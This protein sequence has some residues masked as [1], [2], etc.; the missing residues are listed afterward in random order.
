MDPIDLELFNKGLNCSKLASLFSSPLMILSRF[1]KAADLIIR[2][3]VRPN[4]SVSKTEGCLTRR[5]NKYLVICMVALT[6]QGCG[7]LLFL[8]SRYIISVAI[9][10]V[11][12]LY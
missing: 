2:L 10:H 9:L 12:M 5:Y 8:S 11:K 6:S 7:M 3:K 1:R 4:V